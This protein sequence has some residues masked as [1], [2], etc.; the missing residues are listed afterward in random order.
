MTPGPDPTPNR[1]GGGR[2]GAVAPSRTSLVLAVVIPVVTLGALAATSGEPAPLPGPV[3]PKDTALTS[4][5]VVCPP[6]ITGGA[7]S[8]SNARNSGEAKLRMG[9]EQSTVTVDQDKTTLVD[10]ASSVV[11]DGRGALAPG[12]VAGRIDE[13]SAAATSCVAPQPDYW[14]TGVGSASIHSSELELV[15]PDAGRAIADVEIYGDNGVLPIDAVRGVTVPGGTATAIDLAETAPD[16]SELTVHVTVT[17]GRLGASMV[18]RIAADGSY[19]DWLP[20]QAEPASSTVLLG[21]ADGK[22]ERQLVVANPSD[23]QARVQIKVIGSDSTFAALGLDELSIPPQ[24]VSVTDV[25][26]VVGDAV[27][28]EESGLLVTSTVPVTSGLRSVVGSPA[29]D[30]S[31]AVAGTPVH[32]AALLLPEGKATLVLAAPTEADSVN[33]TSYDAGG[34]LLGTDRVAV[35]RLTCAALDL[36]RKTALVD[37]RA[38]GTPLPGAVRVV[39]HSGVVTLPLQELVLRG[40]VPAVS[41]GWVQS[42]P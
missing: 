26:D 18:N 33:V 3:P 32:E 36:P 17:R 30:L 5:Q 15:N 27:A 34:K 4:L 28:K 39:T 35:K 10:A 6:P 37:V 11:V 19:A 24:S 42:A 20:P 12:L 25:G 40:L 7:V 21:L 2:H 38:E 9:D 41:A 23:D 8:V 22:G 16:R 1:H 13:K 14:F 31:H 29:E